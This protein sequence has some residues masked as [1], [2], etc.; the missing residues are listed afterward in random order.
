MGIVYMKQWAS[1]DINNGHRLN[2]TMGIV[3]MQ[4]WASFICNI[5]TCLRNDNFLTYKTR[6]GNE[7]AIA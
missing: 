6:R 4:Q 5:K 7:N 3:Y 2:T 1:F